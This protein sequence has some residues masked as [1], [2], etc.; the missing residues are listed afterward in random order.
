M[1]VGDIVRINEEEPVVWEEAQGQVGMIVSFGKRLYI[2]EAKV[3][4][5]GE[6]AQ[7]DLDELE[8]INESR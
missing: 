4:I 2:P 8:V 5:L 1:K 6:I 3:M 7:Y